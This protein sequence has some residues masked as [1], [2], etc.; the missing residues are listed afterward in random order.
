M[1][2]LSNHRWGRATAKRL[3]YG[4]AARQAIVQIAFS[5]FL[6]RNVKLTPEQCDNISIEGE[7]K[8]WGDRLRFPDN[9]WFERLLKK[10]IP[11]HDEREIVLKPWMKSG[12]L[13]VPLQS[14]EGRPQTN[15]DSL[16]LKGGVRKFNVRNLPSLDY[17]TADLK[18]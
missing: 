2:T 14:E 16:P 6:G 17:G 8:I 3:S 11:S 12:Q 1:L 4:N 10:Q 9:R 13:D 5:Q 7:S 15:I 18:R